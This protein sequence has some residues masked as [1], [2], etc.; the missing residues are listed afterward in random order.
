[1][2]A[3]QDFDEGAA[4][5]A[6]NWFSSGSVFAFVL[7]ASVL[8]C[9]AQTVVTS[10]AVLEVGG[11][12]PGIAEL[13][14]AW[15]IQF[16]KSSAAQALYRLNFKQVAE[17]VP[18]QAGI[19]FCPCPACGADDRDD[20][21]VWTIE[22]PKMLK[23]RRCGVSLPN[24][25]IPA[26][27]NKEIP[28]ETV[29]VLPG[30]LHHYPYH[31]VEES[32]ARFPEERVY[33]QA[34]IDH[35]ARKYLAKAALYAA[36]EYG[37]Q[38]VKARD[39][40][41]A[42]LACVIMLRFAQVYPAYAI[43]YDQPGRPKFFQPARPLPP[44]RRG[45]ESG[46]WESSGSV[47]VPMNLVAAYS[48][49]R[50][51]PAWAEAGRTVAV[52]SPEQLVANDLFRVAAEFAAAQPD[53]FTEESLYVYRGIM[54]VGRL[55]D[56]PRLVSGAVTRIEAFTQRGF[57]HDGFWKGAD[58]QSHLRV[59]GL[60]EGLA[61]K[62]PEEG[63][64]PILNL[65]RQATAAIGPRIADDGVQ[66]ASLFSTPAP[67]MKRRAALLGGAGLARLAVGEGDTALDLEIR[68]PDSFGGPHFQRLALKLWV[69]GEPV[70]DDL[71]DRGHRTSGWELAT[72]S[73]NTVMVDGLNQ[74][75]TPTV[76]GNPAAGG[77]FSYFAADPD[78]QVVSVEDKRAYPLSTTRYR[79]TVIVA[80]RARGGYAVSVFEVHGGSQHDQIFHAATGRMD[81]WQLAA[82]QYP[83]ASLLPRSIRYL[84]GARPADGRWFVQSLGEFQP[85]AQASL[86][87]PSLAGLVAST[88]ASPADSP[89]DVSV[90]RKNHRSPDLRLHILG[91][92]PVTAYTALSPDSARPAQAAGQQ[93]AGACRSSLIL[94]R[95]STQ[96][97]PLRSTFV[98]LFEPGVSGVRPLRRVGR[99]SSRPDVVV[100]M[101][102]DEAGPEYLLV[103]LAPGTAQSVSLPGSRYVSFDGLALRVRADGLV[104]AGG[105]FAEGSGRLV[106]RANM[107]G[108][109]TASVRR[110]DGRALGWFETP[111]RLP[112]DHALAGR[113][114]MVQHGDGTCRSWTLEAIES[115]PGGSRLHVREVPGFE[116]DPHTREA[117][118][119]QF[120]HVTAPGPHRF[121]LADLARSSGSEKT[122]HKNLERL[123]VNP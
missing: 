75:E 97:H 79:H 41:L 110:P 54:M 119:Y 19:R 57:Y 23:C 26:K 9:R 47:E 82:A 6:G 1:M 39:R 117:R 90:V 58:S 3:K 102:E 34:K 48:L 49:L 74:R 27:V 107:T 56:D 83:P 60:I 31:V 22:L 99:V 64:M 2:A 103:N 108:A 4:K 118:Y 111:E 45:Y 123:I 93:P 62:G 20:P 69:G 87:G 71:D 53:E 96:G 95:V 109:L 29:Q 33:L 12:L 24:D 80:G 68:A 36:A 40:K 121:R 94:R 89:P 25:K 88:G 46:K 85:L 66:Q 76:A 77:D 44:L 17:L 28:E 10:R 51:D 101:V 116:I 7:L 114:L 15:R 78:F 14:A 37:A 70:L 42:V 18:A 73:H 98:T 38:G 30:V 104:L 91:D 100:V 32:K 43:H 50:G 81:R 21:L 63:A 105:T 55:L 67:A 106:S 86:T 65:A 122:D 59:L 112:E 84:E 61:R 72:A 115:Y 120:P 11:S 92:T 35:E 16:W 13:P 52:A 5:V 8:P 113:S